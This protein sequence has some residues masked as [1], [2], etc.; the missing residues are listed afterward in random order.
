MNE[1]DTG[2]RYDF[3]HDISLTTKLIQFWP[4]WSRIFLL[5]K[6]PWHLLQPTQ[7]TK[8]WKSCSEKSMAMY[9]VCL[10]LGGVLSL[11]HLGAMITLIHGRRRT[12]DLSIESFSTP[13]CTDVYYNVYSIFFKFGKSTFTE[14]RISCPE[15]EM[16]QHQTSDE[17]FY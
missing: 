3:I 6:M 17:F 5:C 16:A 15:N 2:H 4:C 11:G 7:A 9:L 12:L 1:H 13:A 10:K 14:R 8:L